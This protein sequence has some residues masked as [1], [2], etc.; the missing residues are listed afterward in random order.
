VTTRTGRV[1]VYPGSFNPPTIAH[2]AIADTARRTYGLDRVDLAVS[3]VALAKEHVQH[4]PFEVRVEAIRAA[5]AGDDGLG[6]LITDHQLIADIASGYDVVIM[7]AD[8]WHQIMDPIF[9]SD[10]EQARDAAMAR[11]PTVA[12]VPR[13]PLE[14]PEA[15]ALPIP[16]HYGDVSST[17]IRQRGRYDW[18]APGAVDIYRPWLDAEPGA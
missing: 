1:G 10:S 3:R 5:I 11:L 17:A 9:Y 16:D 14:I 6:L 8:K 12:L 4:P 7:G 2:L 13:P 15:M 18:L